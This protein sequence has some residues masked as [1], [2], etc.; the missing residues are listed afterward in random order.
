M[1]ETRITHLRRREQVA[2]ARRVT[3]ESMFEK[4]VVK[5]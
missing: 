4:Q 2:V 1:G 5:I 3:L